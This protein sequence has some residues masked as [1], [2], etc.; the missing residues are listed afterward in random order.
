MNGLEEKPGKAGRGVGLGVGVES[1]LVPL[2]DRL[3]VSLTNF[4][5]LYV[6]T[7]ELVSNESQRGDIGTGLRTGTFEID[8]WGYWGIFRRRLGW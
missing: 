8:S 3:V 2:A 7:D 1:A 5:L 4:K 6:T